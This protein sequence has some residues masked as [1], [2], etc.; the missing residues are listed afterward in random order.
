MKEIDLNNKKLLLSFIIVIVLIVLFQFYIRI[1]NHYRNTRLFALESEKYAREIANPVFKID[2]IIIYSGANIEDK[3]QDNN[4][5]NINI[6]Q[7]TDF[8]IYINNKVKSTKLTEENTINNIYIDNIGIEIKSEELNGIKKFSSKNINNLGKYI[9]ISESVKKIDYSVVHKNSDKEL[10]NNSNQFFTDC[11]NPLIFSYVNENFVENKDVSNSGQKLSLDGGMLKYLKIDLNKLNYK[12]NFTI[13]IEN[14]LGEKFFCNC[15]V[16][17]DLNSGEGQG[18]YSGYI[19][20]ILDLS[21]SDL[22]FK[23]L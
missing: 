6:S 13:N 9:P 18:I 11:S 17:V 4:L 5:A 10:I 2:K 15:S 20:Q 12:T 16:N 14:N 1:I 22:R 3:S 21:K 7:F 19:M 8:A 23:K